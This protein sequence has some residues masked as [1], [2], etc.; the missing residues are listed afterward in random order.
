VIERLINPFLRK[1]WTGQFAE[2][3]C[4]HLG[5]IEAVEPEADVCKQCVEI[6]D[7]WPALRMC[8]I[9]GRVGCCEKAKNQHAYKHYEHT[10]HPLIKP[11]LER[12][13]HWT[14]CYADQALLSPRGFRSRSG[15][16][17]SSRRAH[18]VMCG[19]PPS[20]VA[21]FE[22]ELFATTIQRANVP[23]GSTKLSNPSSPRAWMIAH[24]RN[25]PVAM[26]SKAPKTAMIDASERTILGDADQGDDNTGSSGHCIVS[27]R[28]RLPELTGIMRFCTASCRRIK[29]PVGF[30]QDWNGPQ[31]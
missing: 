29:V 5:L 9:C 7:T 8:L 25:R 21:Q 23:K 13:M 2:K 18:N 27:A 31:R 28:Q 4:S 22:I 16:N 24:A 1:A 30:G 3:N 12:G 19:L 10:G 15:A 17:S 11:H 14:W 26:P 20:V 6:G